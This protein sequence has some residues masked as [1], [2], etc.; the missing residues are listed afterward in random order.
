VEVTGSQEAASAV[1][2]P[3]AVLAPSGL[4]VPAAETGAAYAAKVAIA[5]ASAQITR[6]RR[7]PRGCERL[8]W[9][10][11]LLLCACRVF[12]RKP[13]RVRRTVVVNPEECG[14]RLTEVCLSPRY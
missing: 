13:R 2:R 8:C 14:G 11:M 7:R 4:P 10:S 9:P 1:R 6:L 12:E 5:A 3:S